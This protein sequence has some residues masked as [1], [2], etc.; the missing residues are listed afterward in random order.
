MNF[1]ITEL[2]DQDACYARLVEALHPD[3]R[4]PPAS[5]STASASIAATASRSS[6]TAAGLAGGSSMP[7]RGLGIVARCR[8]DRV[9]HGSDA[10][11]FA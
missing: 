3:G 7:P 6:T 5:A 9:S 4:P 8:T 11:G 1:P 2:M 10:T